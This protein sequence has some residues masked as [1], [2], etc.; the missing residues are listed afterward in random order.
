MFALIES[1]SD[2]VIVQFFLPEPLVVIP[3]SWLI[4]SC[5]FSG[6]GIPVDEPEPRELM[7]SHLERDNAPEIFYINF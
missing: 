7:D 5:L 1:M 4:P 6:R 3:E 2:Y